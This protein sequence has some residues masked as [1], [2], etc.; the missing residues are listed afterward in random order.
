[1]YHSKVG[2]VFHIKSSWSQSFLAQVKVGGFKSAQIPLT[3][4]TI[5]RVSNRNLTRSY[6]ATTAVSNKERFPTK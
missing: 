6:P 1:L 5:V 3:L 4:V 2:G